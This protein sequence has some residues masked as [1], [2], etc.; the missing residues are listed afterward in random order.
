MLT[1]R[2]TAK[3]LK[4]LHAEPVATPVPSST[5]LGEWYATILAVRPAHLVLLVNEMTRL[6]V[7]IPA[8]PLATLAERIPDGIARV[9]FELESEP[10]TI[11]KERQAMAHVAFAKTASRS[12]LGTMNEFIFE[13]GFIREREPGMTELEMSLKLGQRLVTV[14]PSGYEVPAEL[15]VLALANKAGQTT[16]PPDRRA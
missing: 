12:V 9:L 11:S 3:L 10:G 13:L 4:R 5:R 7:I 6:P 14:P 15:A 16:S 8:R 2:C 1:V